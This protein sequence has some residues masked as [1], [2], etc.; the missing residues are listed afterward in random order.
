[1][2]VS[3][4]ATCLR[5]PAHLRDPRSVA[6][7]SQRYVLQLYA[8]RTQVATHRNLSRGAP[9]VQCDFGHSTAFKAR[10][11]RFLE[12]YPGRSREMHG[13]PSGSFRVFLSRQHRVRAYSRIASSNPHSCVAVTAAL[14]PNT[15]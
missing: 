7:L 5:A 4:T 15:S 9:M 1:M 11:F 10:F 2:Y 14:V 6:V 8:E 13:R 12:R 3:C